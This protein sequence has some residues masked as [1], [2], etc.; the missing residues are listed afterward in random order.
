MTDDL[1]EDDFNAQVERSLALVRTLL[2]DAQAWP[3]AHE[4]LSAR[5]PLLA[6]P[7]TELLEAVKR[8]QLKPT[9]VVALGCPGCE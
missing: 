1:S 8:A 3:E 2:I 9:I 6:F 4:I 5:E 7:R